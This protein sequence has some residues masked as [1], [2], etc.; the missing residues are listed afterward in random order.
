MSPVSK[1]GA[2][3]VLRVSGLPNG[4]L[5]V[6]FDPFGPTHIIGVKLTNFNSTANFRQRESP[7]ANLVVSWLV[8]Q[9]I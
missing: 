7:P 6:D 4:V 9:A 2:Q 1:G 8:G 5:T 3:G